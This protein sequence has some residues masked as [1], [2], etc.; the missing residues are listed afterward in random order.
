MAFQLAAALVLLFL[1]YSGQVRYRPYMSTD[2]HAAVV[3]EHLA[4]SVTDPLHQRLRATLAAVEATGRKRATGFSLAAADKGAAGLSTFEVYSRAALNYNNVDAF[5]LFAGTAILLCGILF[6]SVRPTD[7]F[8]ARSNLAVLAVAMLIVVVTIVYWFAAMVV[9]I[10]AQIRSRGRGGPTTVAAACGCGGGKRGGG[11]LTSGPS[12]RA[13]PAAAEEPLGDRIF[14]LGLDK[15]DRESTASN[16]LFATASGEAIVT[17]DQVMGALRTMREPPNQS[18]W[19]LIREQLI[20]R[21]AQSAELSAVN[22]ELKGEV[23]RLAAVLEA[24]GLAAGGRG[25]GGGG[26]AA[27]LAAGAGGGPARREFAAASPSGVRG[28]GS[29]SENA[30]ALSAYKTSNPLHAAG[31]R[32]GDNKGANV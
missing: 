4:L 3:R 10:S 32:G 1:S 27:R 20:A 17:G 31:L 23:G 5:M 15:D 21:E 2:E 13:A 25:G 29:P 19:T 28:G 7:S 26:A 12:A 11:K 14:S 16:P 6:V 30:G 18:T 9:D 8:F 24:A 22:A